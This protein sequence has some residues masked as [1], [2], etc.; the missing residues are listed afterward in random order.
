MQKVTFRVMYIV[1][2]TATSLRTSLYVI[3]FQLTTFTP[4]YIVTFV[5]RTADCAVH[6]IDTKRRIRV[7]C[8]D[9]LFIYSCD[10]LKMT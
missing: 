7:W 8:P 5:S 9:D 3:Q 2:Y 4:G 10:H 1:I 6:T